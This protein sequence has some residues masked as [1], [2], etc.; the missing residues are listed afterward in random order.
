M[1]I[2]FKDWLSQQSERNDPAGD[3]SKDVRLD[4]CNH[5][6]KWNGQLKGLLSRI[7]IFNGSNEVRDVIQEAWNEYQET[8][9]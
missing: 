7:L 9:S 6:W 4:Q 3:L 2:S 5:K 8:Q 1:G